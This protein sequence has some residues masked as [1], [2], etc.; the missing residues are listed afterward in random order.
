M[1]MNEKAADK[2]LKA[3]AEVYNPNCVR[4]LSESLVKE[5]GHSLPLSSSTINMLKNIC[6]PGLSVPNVDFNDI[7]M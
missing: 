2:A 3:P 5:C 1:L 4:D 6:L 7:C